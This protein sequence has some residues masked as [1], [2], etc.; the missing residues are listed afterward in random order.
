MSIKRVGIVG[1]G[2]MGS[3]IALLCAH[4]GY[5]TVVSEI[6]EES[7]IRGMQAIDAN[8]AK[9]MNKGRLF[10]HDRDDIASRLSHTT[11]VADFSE[12]DL[13]IEA[14]TEDM[15]EKLN[16]FR[17]LDLVCPPHAILASNSS[18]LSITEMAIATKRPEKVVG[19]HFI[20]PAPVMLLLELVTTV[21]SSEET[22]RA[23][24]KFG[25]S[26]G[27]SVVTVRDEPGYVLNRLMA[28]LILDAIRLLET[29]V[30]T[31]EDI[32]TSM[33]LGCHHPMGPLRLA[34][35]MGLDT[36]LSIADALHEEYKDSKFAPPLSLKRMVAAG[37]LGRKTGKGFY[38]YD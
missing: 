34:D 25:E 26:L 11:E 7:L 10:K 29:G 30:A 35:F 23:A 8:I 38:E 4:A 1:C 16:M 18:C 20:N 3:G 19:L 28:P 22:V 24:G 17:E 31:R 21:L 33:V 6:N 37:H 14:I 32:D 9:G 36:V 15:A 2:Q 13:V 27:K 12:C 5:Q